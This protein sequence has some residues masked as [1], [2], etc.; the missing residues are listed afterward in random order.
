MNSRIKLKKGLEYRE[1]ESYDKLL[2]FVDLDSIVKKERSEVLN[3][4]KDLNSKLN[5]LYSLEERVLDNCLREEGHRSHSELFK[6]FV[7]VSMPVDIRF[8]ALQKEYLEIIMDLYKSIG[9]E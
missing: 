8:F 1:F 6:D 7:D 3:E 9:I 2:K 5:E 4:I